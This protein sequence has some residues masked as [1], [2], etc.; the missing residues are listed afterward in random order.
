MYSFMK[1]Y[2]VFIST[3]HRTMFTKK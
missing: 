1:G 3:I 2:W